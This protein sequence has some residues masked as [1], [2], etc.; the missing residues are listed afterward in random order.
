MLNL[1]L[2]TIVIVF[3]IDLSG[4][5]D[6]LNKIVW[7]KLYKGIKYTDWSIPLIGCSLCLTFHFGWL[8]LLITGTFSFGLLAYVSL[9]SFMTPI[10]KDTMI[11]LRDLFTWILDL[12]YKYIK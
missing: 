4:A 7:N 12:I 10:I 9:L 6:K 8:Y 11:L 2:A 5:M 1:L 3:C